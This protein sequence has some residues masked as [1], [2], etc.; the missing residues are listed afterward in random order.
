VKEVG[1][2]LRYILWSCSLGGIRLGYYQS[3]QY[4]LAYFINTFNS[5]KPLFLC[6]SQNPE[7]QLENYLLIGS[8]VLFTCPLTSS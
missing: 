1:H 8:N 6:R 4:L 3:F 5:A 7:N 2:H